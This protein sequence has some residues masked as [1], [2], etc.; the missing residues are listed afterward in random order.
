[1]KLVMIRIEE[2]TMVFYLKYDTQTAYSNGS[3]LKCESAAHISIISQSTTWEEIIPSVFSYTAQLSVNYS[4]SFTQGWCTSLLESDWHRVE[5]DLTPYLSRRVNIVF[6]YLNFNQTD[7]G[8]VYLDDIQLLWDNC[9]APST[10]GQMTTGQATTNQF[11]TGQYTTGQFTTGQ[12]TT[13]TTAVTPTTGTTNAVQTTGQLT[14]GQSTTS[15]ST[16]GRSTTGRSTTGRATTGVG[17]SAVL[18]PVTTGKDSNVT[19]SSPVTPITGTTTSSILDN[20]MSSSGLIAGWLP[21]NW[22]FYGAGIAG[23]IIVLSIVACIV[24]KQ[25]AK[26]RGRKRGNT[27]RLQDI[28]I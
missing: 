10:T 28:D 17:T 27:I 25:V 18:I 24:Q 9:Q 1:M 8:G 22:I 3:T 6:E 7:F 13:G 4:S 12:F 5:V 23:G 20:Q 15:R 2:V 14:T 11:T 19:T 21:L 26:R 16:T